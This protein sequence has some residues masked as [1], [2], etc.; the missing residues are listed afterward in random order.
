MVGLWFDTLQ[1]S[2]PYPRNAFHLAAQRS[3]APTF[4]SDC[5]VGPGRH[6]VGTVAWPCKPR[7]VMSQKIA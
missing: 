4:P 1:L 6:L 3:G 5:K 7:P 2:Q